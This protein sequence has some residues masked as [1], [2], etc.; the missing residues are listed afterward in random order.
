MFKTCTT[1]AINADK[2]NTDTLAVELELFRFAEPPAGQPVAAGWVPP[3]D[4]ECKTGALVESHA[5]FHHLALMIQTR[6]VPGAMLRRTVAALADSVESQTGRR[7]RGKAMRELKEE[8][9]LQL[10]PKAFPKR[11]V[12]RIILDT[13]QNRMI[14]V[15]ATG[16]A[17][18]SAISA[19]VAMMPAANLSTLRTE[20]STTALMLSWLKDEPP[21]DFSID[22]TLRLVGDQKKAITYRNVAHES[23]S[24]QSSLSRGM[25]PDTLAVTHRGKISATLTDKD[26]LTL[27]GLNVI[28]V[29][30]EKKER[31]ADAW[32]GNALLFA[33][34]VRELVA[35]LVECL[36]G[37]KELPIEAAAREP[38]KEAEPA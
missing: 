19:L 1:L 13:D 25:E 9:L 18:D 28:G 26:G 14:Y 4:P 15:G 33:T 16:K 21:A 22:D 6:A 10:L 12:V 27:K 3:R 37:I 17:L 2:P 8:A 11:N 35:A 32:D 29:L 36:G 38:E 23:E 24:V 5:G 30:P 7:P 20:H 34:E 31:A